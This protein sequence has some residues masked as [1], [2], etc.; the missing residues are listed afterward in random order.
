MADDDD[1]DEDNNN[2]DDSIDFAKKNAVMD[3]LSDAAMERYNTTND[4]AAECLQVL[5]AGLLAKNIEPDACSGW[6]MLRDL[7]T[8][9]EKRQVTAAAASTGAQQ[10]QQRRK[11]KKGTKN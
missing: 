4:T 10:Q 9:E 7:R 3:K 8:E 6:Q 11:V 5:E 2:N 1:I